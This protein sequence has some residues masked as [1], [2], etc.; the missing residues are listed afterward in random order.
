[1]TPV[2]AVS[3]CNRRQYKRLEVSYQAEV[4]FNGVHQHSARVRDLSATGIGLHA[5]TP[6]AE[7]TSLLLKIQ[8]L[9]EGM[10]PLILTAT[11]VHCVTEATDPGYLVGCVLD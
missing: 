2:Q 7:D 10:R 4:H 1:M 6:I 5:D 3:P 11:V 8:P 9:R